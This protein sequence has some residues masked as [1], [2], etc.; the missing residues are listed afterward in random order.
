M[1]LR[2][3][4]LLV[5]VA[6][7]AYICYTSGDGAENGEERTPLGSSNDSKMKFAW[8]RMYGPFKKMPSRSIFENW[9]ESLLLWQQFHNTTKLPSKSID[10]RRWAGALKKTYREV[11]KK[12]YGSKNLPMTSFT[13]FKWYKVLVKWQTENKT[14]GYPSVKVDLFKWEKD[15]EA[16]KIKEEARVKAAK[17][18]RAKEIR[19]ELAR[20]AEA[21]RK[22]KDPC[23]WVKLRQK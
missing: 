22:A 19:E 4:I 9:Y 1:K 10:I 6:L 21:E 8:I 3:G 14:Q 7:S 2:L 23:E 20:R 11:W 16:A 17:A 13:L 12:A 15:L 18:A 5:I